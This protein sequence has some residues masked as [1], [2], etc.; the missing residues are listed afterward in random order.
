MPQNNQQNLSQCLKGHL[1]LN[2]KCSYCRSLKSKWDRALSESGFVDIERNLKLVNAQTTTPLESLR[3]FQS[4]AAFNAR[5]SYYQ[6]ARSVLNTGRF[7]SSK[8]RRI[9]EDYAEGLS[10]RKIS[11]RI[12]FEQSWVVRKIHKIQHSLI[13]QIVGSISMSKSVFFKSL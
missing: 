11:K 6:W 5:V 4:T 12:G 1:V 9:W 13:N 10:T 8:D 2:H 3:D 7:D